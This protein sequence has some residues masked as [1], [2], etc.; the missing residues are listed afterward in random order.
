MVVRELQF[1][2]LAFE[3]G[4]WCQ[5]RRC[6]EALGL[7]RLA[8]PPLAGYCLVVEAV[9]RELAMPVGNLGSRRLLG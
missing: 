5:G 3:V 1:V 2:Y 7:C 9:E 4:D 8:W 6:V